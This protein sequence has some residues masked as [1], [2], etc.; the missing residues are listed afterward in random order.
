MYRGAVIS[1]ATG[2]GGRPW[3]PCIGQKPEWQNNPAP[4]R[5]INAWAANRYEGLVFSEIPVWGILFLA[6]QLAF[7]GA[8]IASG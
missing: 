1:I 2:A 7:L 3:L 4:S 5:F 6:C 8:R